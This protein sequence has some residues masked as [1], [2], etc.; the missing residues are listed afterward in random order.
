MVLDRPFS[1]SDKSWWKTESWERG[2]C[3]LRGK[4]Q[5]HSQ[6]TFLGTWERGNVDDVTIAIFLFLSAVCGLQSAVCS[7]QS[8]NVIHRYIT[9]VTQTQ[10]FESFKP[11][12][13]DNF[14]KQPFT[15]CVLVPFRL[16]NYKTSAILFKE[17]CSVRST[18]NQLQHRQAL[19]STGRSRTTENNILKQYLFKLHLKAVLL[20]NVFWSQDIESVTLSLNIFVK[21][22]CCIPRMEGHKWSRASLV[23]SVE[24][25]TY[26]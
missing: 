8:A 22:V 26:F 3:T 6:A 19:D 5:P 25:Q 4:H 13:I 23:C 15:V 10:W 20:R 2:W 18:T 14:K 17:T 9:V 21:Y 16:L 11:L 7:L 12:I 1:I 24:L